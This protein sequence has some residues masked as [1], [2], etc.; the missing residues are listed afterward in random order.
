[1]AD[2]PAGTSTVDV[3]V[4]TPSGTSAPSPADQFGY[5]ATVSD[6][7][8]SAGPLSDGTLMTITGLGF[9]G[10]TAVEFGTTAAAIDWAE[11]RYRNVPGRRR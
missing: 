4:T 10:A 9:I 1:M 5:M 11:K 7:S 2:S 8:H 6:V 3:T